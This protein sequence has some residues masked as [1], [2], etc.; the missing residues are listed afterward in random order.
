MPLRN[1]DE[2]DEDKEED[3]SAPLASTEDGSPGDKDDGG[4]EYDQEDDRKD[5]VLYDSK[6]QRRRR[7]IGARRRIVVVGFVGYF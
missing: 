1:E 7:F 4:C 2:E 3:F 5:T 6:I